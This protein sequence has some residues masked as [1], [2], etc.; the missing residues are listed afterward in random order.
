MSGAK[1]NALSLP[2]IKYKILTYPQFSLLGLFFLSQ[3]QTIQFV[4][5]VKKGVNSDLGF[6]AQRQR[7][8]V[9]EVGYT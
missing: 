2:L 7:E 1:Y 3:I 9:K 4:R 6:I 8:G 5:S